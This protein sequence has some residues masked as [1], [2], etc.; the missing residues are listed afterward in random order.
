MQAYCDRDIKAH[1]GGYEGRVTETKYKYY[2]LGGYTAKSNSYT[3]DD[4]SNIIS[5]TT[6]EYDVPIFSEVKNR[7]GNAV[8]GEKIG[9][10]KETRTNYTYGKKT[11]YYTNYHYTTYYEGEG[12]NPKPGYPA[13]YY[14]PSSG[15]VFNSPT[16]Y[17]GISQTITTMINPGVYRERTFAK[18]A[19]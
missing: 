12:D 6:E 17:E 1:P 8:G 9:S 11:Q 13:V 2:R 18:P 4:H 14:D 15:A 16:S 3:T 19:A 10:Y 5:Q 7:K